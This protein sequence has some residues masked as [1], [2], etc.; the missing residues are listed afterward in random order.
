MDSNDSTV[1]SVQYVARFLFTFYCTKTHACTNYMQAVITVLYLIASA[2]TASRIPPLF[3]VSAL[4]YC[5]RYLLM[6]TSQMNVHSSDINLGSGVPNKCP[7]WISTSQMEV[8]TIM[9]GSLVDGYYD[10]DNISIF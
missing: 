3:C 2:S 6:W 5:R 7:P 10:V 1:L 4:M 8:Y 9:Q